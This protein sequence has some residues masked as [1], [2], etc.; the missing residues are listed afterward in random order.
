VKKWDTA[1]SKDTID[2]I[3]KAFHIEI[4]VWFEL[5]AEKSRSDCS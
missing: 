5:I 1:C 2:K 4:E 3:Y